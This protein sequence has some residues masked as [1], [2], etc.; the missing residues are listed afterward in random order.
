MKR[1]WFLWLPLLVIVV[2]LAYEVT[3]SS[4]ELAAM[5]SEN[6]AVELAQWVVIM[7]AMGVAF[8]TLFKLSPRQNPFLFGW[9]LIAG[10]ACLYI[11]WEEVS[12]G[13]HFLNWDTP[14]YWAVVND[15][16]ETNLHNTTSWLDQK[17]RL[18]LMIGIVLGGIVFP[19]L[20]KFKPG[21]LPDKFNIIYPGAAL[22]PV[23]ILVIG[24]YLLDKVVNVFERVSEVQELYM[25]YFVLLYLIMLRARITQ[26]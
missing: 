4:A 1:F 21:I 25:Y 18:I 23:A 8:A 19:L 3:H 10:L 2:Q 22:L 16:Q 26:K 6:G 9:V 11:A 24:P 12:W 5:M 20:Q 14:S 17:P 13:Q 7:L 15:Q